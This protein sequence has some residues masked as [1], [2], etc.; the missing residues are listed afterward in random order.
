MRKIIFA[1]APALMLAGCPALQPK[2]GSQQIDVNVMVQ[3]GGR[4]IGVDREPIYVH[5]R[6]GDV[7]IVWNVATS[8]YEFTA[9]GIEIINGGSEFNCSK[10]GPVVFVCIDRYTK[11]GTYKYVIRLQGSGSAATPPTLDPTVVNN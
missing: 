7:P 9:N 8:G 5:E 4:G 11:P 3:P 10:K 1:V 2:L 6:N